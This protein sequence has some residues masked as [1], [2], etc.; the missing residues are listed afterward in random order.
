MPGTEAAFDSYAFT[1]D[2][3]FTYSPVGGMQ[4]KRVWRYLEKNLSPAKHPDVLEL[5]CGTGEDA[6]WLAN[7]GYNV[8]A[9]DLSGE[10]AAVAKR[11]LGGKADVFQSGIRE[12]PG[13]TG[14]KTFDL[15][16]SD[17]GGMNCIGPADMTNVSAELASLLNPG[18]RLVL[19]VMSRN[20]KWEQFYF[21]RKN[22]LASAY[23][24]RSKQP[25][26]A[27]IFGEHFSTWYYSP[28][29]LA[30]FFS[31]QFSL[32]TSKPI[33]IAL[34]PSYLDNWFRRR[35][36]LLSLLNVS[37]KILGNFSSLSDK[38][39]HFLIDLSKK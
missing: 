15:I 20:C 32:N 39:D 12:I 25:V 23:R 26:E 28:G 4:R 22:N 6:L 11:K 30:E 31:A 24:R 10:M 16:F 37:E 38:A 13:K 3:E 34:P 1:Y 14:G 2:A 5:N 36:F 27:D 7:R 21:R 8:T 18:G 33:G 17:F 35:R 29:E 19:V 9:T